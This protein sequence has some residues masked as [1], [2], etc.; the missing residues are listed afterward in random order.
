MRTRVEAVQVPKMLPGL[1]ATLA[2]L[3]LLQLMGILGVTGLQTVFGATS[4]QSAR[5]V[6]FHDDSYVATNG[7]DPASHVVGD[8]TPRLNPLPQPTLSYL[9]SQLSGHYNFRG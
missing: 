7:G 4:N 5:V 6:T 2:L 8:Q 9:P 1:M 3:L